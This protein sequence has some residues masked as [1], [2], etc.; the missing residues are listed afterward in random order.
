MKLFKTVD[1][2]FA[3]LGFEKIEESCY[4]VVYERYN[5]EYKFTQVLH[6]AHKASGRHIV[7]S[8]DKDLSDA[9]NIGSTCVG[10]S[11]YE[12]ELCLKKMRQ[13]GWKMTK[14]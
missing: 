4:G 9:K 1:D 10:L 8:Y 12:M 5:E 11:M 2:R 13:L 14:N 3:D 6:L 7:Q